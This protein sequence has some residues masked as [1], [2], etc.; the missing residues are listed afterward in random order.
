MEILTDDKK[1]CQKLIPSSSAYEVL[2]RNMSLHKI[3]PLLQDI[4]KDQR[5]YQT[6]LPDQPLLEYGLITKYASTSQFRILLKHAQ[7]N[8]LPG[9]ILCLADVGQGF[10][11]YRDRTWTSVKGNLHL[12]A[13]LKPDQSVDHFETGFTILSAV[14]AIQAINEIINLK[15]MAHIRWIND[16]VIGNTKIGG[17]LTHTFSQATI[18]TGVILGI[19]INVETTPDVEKDIFVPEVASLFDYI[20]QPDANLLSIVLHNLL[21]HLTANYRL[22]LENRYN[23]LLNTYRT[24]SIILG[25]VGTIYS[26]PVTENSEKIHEGKVIKIGKNLE[27]YFENRQQPVKNGRIVIK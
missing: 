12:S 26:D 8:L 10:S 21:K 1:Y 11:G 20:A 23:E 17:V 16:I 25:K 9:T 7:N 18:V 19:G 13:F 24:H 14:S 2:S 22:L 27:L 3:Y 15:E 5:L 6:S 4:F